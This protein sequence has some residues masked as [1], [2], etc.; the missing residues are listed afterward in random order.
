MSHCKLLKSQKGINGDT[1]NIYESSDGQSFAMNERTG[2]ILL[3][4]EQ[5]LHKMN[6]IDRF[7]REI[8]EISI[9]NG[10]NDC[11]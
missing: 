5:L 7:K 6:I 11:I 4:P 3:T 2:D 8:F 9:K 1:V 10:Y